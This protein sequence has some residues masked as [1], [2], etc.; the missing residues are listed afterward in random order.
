[1]IVK[2]P[3]G[4]NKPQYFDDPAIDSLY[5]MVLILGEELAAAREQIH[6]LT[7]LLDDKDLLSRM[8]A[9]EPDAA[10]IDERRAFV[11]RLLQPLTALVE[12]EKSG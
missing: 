6:T 8:D 7:Q 5:Q 11:D 12:T 9:Y 1:M 2:G 3:D 10:F 4:A